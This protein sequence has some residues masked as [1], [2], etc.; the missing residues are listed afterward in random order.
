VQTTLEPSSATNG[1][2]W[3]P[4]NAN[5][6]PNL[7]DYENLFVFNEKNKEYPYKFGLENSGGSI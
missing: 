3:V 6:H 2:P 1:A 4:E 5:L 7:D